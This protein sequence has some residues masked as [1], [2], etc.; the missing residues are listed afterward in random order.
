MWVSQYSA[1]KDE[2]VHTVVTRQEKLSSRLTEAA[3]AAARQ[4]EGSPSNTV[5]VSNDT[6]AY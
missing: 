5:P 3:E 1:I 6:A 4:A 2:V